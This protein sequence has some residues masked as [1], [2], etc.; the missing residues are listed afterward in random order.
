[1]R[2]AKTLKTAKALGALLILSGCAT[3]RIQ[4]LSDK[5]SANVKLSRSGDEATLRRFGALPDL[6]VVPDGTKCL[7]LEKTTIRCRGLKNFQHV[8]ILDGMYQGTDAW[9]CDSFV[10]HHKVGAL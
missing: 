3:F 4:T 8:R 6:I 7:L 10:S 2:L 1:L 5:R 9:V